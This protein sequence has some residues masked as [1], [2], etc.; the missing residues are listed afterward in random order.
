[1]QE[2]NKFALLANY[3]APSVYEYPADCGAYES[4]KTVLKHSVH[5]PFLQGD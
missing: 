3:V 2:I 4:A 1:M 5:P